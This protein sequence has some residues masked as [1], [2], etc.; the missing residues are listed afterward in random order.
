MLG[1]VLQFAVNPCRDTTPLHTARKGIIKVVCRLNEDFST[2]TSVQ[3]TDDDGQIVGCGLRV[4][5]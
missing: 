2:H 4:Y 5:D 1:G 3:D